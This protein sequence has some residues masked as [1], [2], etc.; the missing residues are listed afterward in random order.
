MTVQQIKLTIKRK[1][2]LFKKNLR[3]VE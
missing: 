2:C 1:K 3:K